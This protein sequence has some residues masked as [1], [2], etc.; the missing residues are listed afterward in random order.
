MVTMPLEWRWVLSAVRSERRS[1][2]SKGTKCGHECSPGTASEWAFDKSLPSR[3]DML[4]RRSPGGYTWSPI[5]CAK[6]RSSPNRF[7]CIP[8]RRIKGLA[9]GEWTTKRTPLLPRRSARLCSKKGALRF[10]RKCCYRHR[11]CCHFGQRTSHF[12]R[13]KFILYHLSGLWLKRYLTWGSD[14]SRALIWCGRQRA[15]CLRQSQKTLV[16]SPDVDRQIQQ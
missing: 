3:S 15:I 11:A 1:T 5:S 10:L 9:Q 13:P 2:H 6:M 8:D 16:T 14:F 4:I 12:Y 7:Q